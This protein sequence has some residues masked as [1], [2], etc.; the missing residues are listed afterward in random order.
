M[1]LIRK[2]PA[3]APAIGRDDRDVFA[4]L[5]DGTADERWGAARSIVTLPGG[6]EALGAALATEADERVRT[7]MF[8]SLTRVAQPAS[9]EAV[10]PYLRSDDANLRTGALDALRAMPRAVLSRLPE[11]LRDADADVRLLSCEIARGLS[12]SEATALLCDLLERERH[13]NVCASAV[14]VLADIGGPQAVPALRRCALRFPDDAFLG[15]AIKMAVQRVGTQ[16]GDAR[17][18]DT[19]D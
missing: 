4:T 13:A 5:V 9:V 7:A 8:T 16:A 11:L 10:L 17:A 19:R 3:G 18:S 14:D 15:F 2:G 6:V 1:P 12:S